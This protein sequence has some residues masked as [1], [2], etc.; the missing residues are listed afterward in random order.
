MVRIP[1]FAELQRH[2][3][4]VFNL[5]NASALGISSVTAKADRFKEYG[6]G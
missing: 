6:F 1:I 3:L 5:L 2:I 4:P